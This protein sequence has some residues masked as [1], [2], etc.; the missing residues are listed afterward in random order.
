MAAGLLLRFLAGA[1]VVFP[2]VFVLL[3]T[4][5]RSLTACFCCSASLACAWSGARAS[6][7]AAILCFNLH[8]GLEAVG[9]LAPVLVHSLWQCLWAW[10]PGCQVMSW[11]ILT[12]AICLFYQVPWPCGA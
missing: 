2:F 8:V 9:A 1:S 7:V 5:L 11:L 6:V 4:T 12:C 10:A 3:L